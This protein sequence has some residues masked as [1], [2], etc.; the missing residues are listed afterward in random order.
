MKIDSDFVLIDVKEGRH[1]LLDRV[2]S[3]ERISVIVRGYIYT[4]HSMDDGTG[5]EFEVRPTSVIEVRKQ[6][7]L[8]NNEV[9]ELLR[10]V[11]PKKLCVRE[12]HAIMEEEAGHE[13]DKQHISRTLCRA[14]KVFLVSNKG[15]D[16]CAVIR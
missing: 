10:R 12:I 7:P 15:N 13:I 6:K 2:K 4:D 5:I 9:V 8:N 14:K 11:Y 1:K 3:G 16:W